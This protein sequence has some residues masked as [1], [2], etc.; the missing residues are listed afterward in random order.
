MSSLRLTSEQIPEYV[1]QILETYT[2]NPATRYS[3]PD[4][5]FWEVCNADM[6]FE[7]FGFIFYFPIYFVP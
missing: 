5:N 1:G 6:T 3:N 2:K 7:M 4:L